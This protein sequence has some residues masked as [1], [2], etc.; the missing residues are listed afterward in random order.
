MLR[1]SPLFAVL[2]TLCLS[3]F[4]QATTLVNLDFNTAGQY[5]ANFR[6]LGGPA[7]VAQVTTGGQSGVGILGVTAGGTAGAIYDTSPGDSLSKTSF[8][9]SQDSP[10]T[11]SADVRVLSDRS[12][13]FY[14]FSASNESAPGYLALFNITDTLAETEQFRVSTDAL[15]SGVT[16][17]TLVHGSGSPLNANMASSTYY[18]VS[19]EYAINSNNE[20]V[21]TLTANGFSSTYTATGVTAMTDIQIGW[22]ANSTTSASN[23]SH[24]VF[25]NFQISQVPE[26]SSLLLLG[27]GLAA[28][29]R[30]SRR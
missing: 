28:G 21:F 15:A 9:V 4:A 27:A 20:P 25:D 1:T 3:T 13:G 18:P 26:P 12:F 10:I 11:M 14:I 16:A 30:R 6:S 7:T 23:S 5:E 2:S 22:R 19:V 8:T 29:L 24:V 17:G